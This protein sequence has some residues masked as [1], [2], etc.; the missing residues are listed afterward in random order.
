MIP[1][2]S[3]DG[4]D[5]T[6]ATID[7]TDVTEIT[8]DGDTVFTSTLATH[9]YDADALSLANGDPVN[10]FP[11][12][13]GSVDFDI[14]N[15]AP[16]YN[17]TGIG[18]LGTIQANKSEFL[19]TDATG[20]GISNPFT[21]IAVAELVGNTDFEHLYS[22]SI[23]GIIF[24]SDN[25]GKFEPKDGLSFSKTPK[26]FDPHIFTVDFDT[27]GT[28]YIDGA[29]VGSGGPLDAN[30]LDEFYLFTR[31]DNNLG[32][33]WNLGE[34]RIYDSVL[35]SSDRNAEESELSTKW[36]ITI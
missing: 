30:D 7:G 10:T 28:F 25:S 5:I 31:S 29:F 19:R 12:S 33:E 27:S 13:V 14:T 9:I 1:P 26:D 32:G 23:T 16:S 17:N 3:I 22:H 15:D 11:D 36:G 20:F 24:R 4:T 6:G 2:T 18:G 21:I 35:S 8:V 34:L